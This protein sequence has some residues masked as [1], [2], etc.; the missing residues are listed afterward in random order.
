[1]QGFI[2]NLNKVKDEDLIVT[3]LSKDNLYT[4]YR[5]YG[6]RHG[7]INLGFKIDY[8]Q[9]ASAKSTISR[10]KDVIH[11]GYKWINDNKLLRVWQD[12]V[13]LFHK[14]LKDAEELDEFY[15]NLLQSASLNWDKQNPK[16]IAI[17]SYVELL[18]YEGRL[19]T[20]LECFLCNLP[21][22]K[23]VS[24]IRAFL[25][26][27]KECTHTFSIKED[28]FHELLQNKS[29]IFLSDNEVERLWYILL[30]GL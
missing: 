8:E 6:A 2:L 10:L 27:H 30:E 24:L 15:F 1:M 25:P 14:H 21:I 7:V 3:I 9:D 4:L 17:E 23:D 22:Q 5:F 26:T 12:F 13:A 29:T 16:R 19:H 20:E 11:I 28:A 18:E